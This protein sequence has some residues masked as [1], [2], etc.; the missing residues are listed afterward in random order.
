MSTA[1]STCKYFRS[2]Y[3]IINTTMIRKMFGNVTL[4]KS[5]GKIDHYSYASCLNNLKLIIMQVVY[6]LP[7]K[8]SRAHYEM[9]GGGYW[10]HTITEVLTL[11]RSLHSNIY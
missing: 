1:G 8:I 6:A 3:D 2:N 10:V 4:A 11:V 5:M 9:W 7:K